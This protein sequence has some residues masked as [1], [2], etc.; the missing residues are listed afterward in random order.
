MFPWQRTCSMTSVMLRGI[1][2]LLIQSDRGH[3]GREMSDFELGE[4]ENFREVTGDY[5]GHSSWL[6]QWV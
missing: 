1:M 5:I 2:G 3:G 6:N 4:A